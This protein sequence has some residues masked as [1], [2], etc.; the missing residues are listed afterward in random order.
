M[1][2]QQQQVSVKQNKKR[3][4]IPVRKETDQSSLSVSLRL[5]F[6]LSVLTETHFEGLKRWL[7]FFHYS[8]ILELDIC[9]RHSQ[10]LLS[11]MPMPGYGK[12]ALRTY[13]NIHGEFFKVFFIFSDKKNVCYQI[14]KKINLDNMTVLWY[15]FKLSAFYDSMFK[16]TVADRCNCCKNINNNNKISK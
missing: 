16:S 8:N 15:F 1:Q 3:N 10:P 14:I 5:A 7:C 11:R 4:V 12:P 6:S 2:S 13:W 9:V